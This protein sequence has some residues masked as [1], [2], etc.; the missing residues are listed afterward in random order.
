MEILTHK[1][2]EVPEDA[3][4][5]LITLMPYS[6]HIKNAQNGQYII[7]NR[8]NLKMFGFTEESEFIGLTLD[9]LN[10]FMQPHWGKEFA[11]KVFLSDEK[12]RLGGKTESLKNL[13]FKD[14]NNFICCQDMYKTPIFCKNN[15]K[16]V[17]MILT[18]TFEY[19]D[20]MCLIELYKK[21]KDIHASKAEALRYF[22]RYLK[23]DKYLYEP[24]T[25]KEILC[26]LYAVHNQSHKSIAANLEIGL[27]TVETH[28]SN[29]S[30]KLKNF[31]IQDVISCLRDKR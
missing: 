31:S 20:K 5:E 21:Y 3:M 18:V 16:K 15:T 17:G 23:I 7:S 11:E 24:L 22:M 30:N 2:L 10:D 12:V 1:L 13:V 6:T 9:G 26:L 4:F 14:K 25:D 19:S 8:H 28:L 29:I 27:R